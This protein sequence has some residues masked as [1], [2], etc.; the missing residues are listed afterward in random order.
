MN[1]PLELEDAQARLL[2]LAGTLPVEHLAID[3][4][5]GH[6]LAAPLMAR[7]TQ[8]AEDLSAMDGYAVRADDLAG[9]WRVVGESAA[10]HPFT[11]GIATGET[12]RIS[13]GAPVPAGENAVLVQE[14]CTRR[15]DVLTLTGDGPSPPDTHIR[16]KGMDF[17]EGTELLGAGVRI[18]PAQMALAITAGHG[19]LPVRRRVRVAIIDS[20]D[21]LV[22]AGDDCAPHQIPASNGAM[23]AAMAGHMPVD[24]TRIGPVGDSI[25][26]LLTALA[27]AGDADV[28]VTSGGA[29]VGDHDL[30]QPALA[31]WGAE[32]DFWKVAIKPG[33]PLLVAKR[34]GQIII[35]LPG[36][37]VSSMVTGYFFLLPLL[38]RMLGAT[39]VMPRRISTHLAIAMASGGA[40]REF[41]RAIWDGVGVCPHA[42]HDSGALASLA[43]CN[44]L[45]DRAKNADAAKAGEQVGI[46]LLENGG[47]A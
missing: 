25:H 34:D 3:E 2:A 6:Y 37:P 1:A 26:A 19:H 29:S 10:G 20:G 41:V 18:G 38:R 32:V 30:I 42:Q 21:E 36:N 23:L 15:G 44:A 12:V 7:R 35:G 8:P 13:T 5:L 28:I 40:R 27:D 22:G 31:A 46:Y 14:D 33:K 47:I 4:A 11:G 39:E 9:P 24:I 17:V 45:I 43:L 16:R